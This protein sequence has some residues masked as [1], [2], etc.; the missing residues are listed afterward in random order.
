MYHRKEKFYHGL[1][2]SV[3]FVTGAVFL[4]FSVHAGV[5]DVLTEIDKIEKEEVQ[6]NNAISE[7]VEI[8]KEVSKVEQPSIPVKKENKKKSLFGISLMGG[9]SEFASQTTY[10][11]SQ[12]S[13]GIALDLHLTDKLSLESSFMYAQ[14]DL[15][16]GR[17]GHIINSD[18]YWTSIRPAAFNLATQYRGGAGFKYRLWDKSFITPVVGAGLTLMKNNSILTNNQ[19]YG[20]SAM[21]SGLEAQMAANIMGGLELN[22]GGMRVGGMVKAYSTL[23]DTNSQNQVYR[24]AYYPYNSVYNQRSYADPADL[25]NNGEFVEL[26]GVVSFDL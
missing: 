10:I 16:K 22:F 8:T 11:E 18:P 14:F 6:V 19:V 5:D 24:S 17:Y 23:A 20:T 26:L 2:K 3:I 9:T 13:G 1:V 4:S 21:S 25:K 12:F 7:Q 15:P